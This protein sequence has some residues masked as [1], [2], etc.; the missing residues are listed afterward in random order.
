MNDPEILKFNTNH[1]KTVW[2]DED[3]KKAKRNIRRWFHSGNDPEKA[4][5]IHQKYSLAKL[6][7]ANNIELISYR[8]FGGGRRSQVD[9]HTSLD[10]YSNLKNHMKKGYK[11]GFK[12][13]V[14]E[15]ESVCTKKGYVCYS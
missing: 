6:N 8:H 15:I 1:D 5:L 13:V 11:V 10:I 14:G 7:L 9:E 4:R 12:Q 3:I 2:L